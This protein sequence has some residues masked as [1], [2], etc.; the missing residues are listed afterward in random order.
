MRI[1][2]IELTVETDDN[3]TTEGFVEKIIENC[4]DSYDGF[5][6][7]DVSA[8]LIDETKDEQ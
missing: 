4:F 1:F 3:D 5:I 7:T 8:T 2:S 6:A